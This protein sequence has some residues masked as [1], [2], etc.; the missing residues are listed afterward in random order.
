[1]QFGRIHGIA[2]VVLGI[3]LFAVQGILSMMP[4]LRD[5]PTES[6]SSTMEHKTTPLPAIIGAASLVVGGAL[7]VMSRRRDEPDA[8]YAVK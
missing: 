6:S 3:V 2:L 4:K 1:M 5:V 8:K 7:L